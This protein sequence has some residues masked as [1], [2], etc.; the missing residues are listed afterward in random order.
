MVQEKIVN[1]LEYFET[2]INKNSP[3][4]KH[5]ER[6]WNFC[7]LCDFNCLQ[8]S[9]KLGGMANQSIKIHLIKK[10]NIRLDKSKW[11]MGTQSD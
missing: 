11:I 6:P 10:H 1:I 3:A 9:G 5:D 8:G 2:K 7:K 4:G